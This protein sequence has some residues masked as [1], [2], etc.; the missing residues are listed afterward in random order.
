MQTIDRPLADDT[1]FRVYCC[2]WAREELETR[3]FPRISLYQLFHGF[4]MTIPHV[5]TPKY[6]Y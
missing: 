5:A 3:E 4:E 6:E 1:P 2:F